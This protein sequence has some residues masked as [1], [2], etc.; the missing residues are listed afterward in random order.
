MHYIEEDVKT[1]ST[2]M[3]ISFYINVAISHERCTRCLAGSAAQLPGRRLTYPRS[4]QLVSAPAQ[5][6]VGRD[7]SGQTRAGRAHLLSSSEGVYRKE[8]KHMPKKNVSIKRPAKGSTIGQGVKKSLTKV[9]NV[10]NCGGTGT[11][12]P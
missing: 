11:I 10:L 3:V 2:E 8:G 12:K 6:M 7:Q 5:S 4:L 9:R 1:N